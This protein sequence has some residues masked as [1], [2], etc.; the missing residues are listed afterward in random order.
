MKLIDN[1]FE[2]IK[3]DEITKKGKSIIVNKEYVIKKDGNNITNLYDYLESRGFINFPTILFNKNGYNVF[4]YLDDS[5]NPKEQKAYDIFTLISLLHEKTTYY[6]PIDIDEYKEIYENLLNEINYKLNYYNNLIS[7]IETHMFWSPSEYL[8]ARNISKILGALN[9]SKNNLDNWYDIVKTKSNKRIVTI[10]NNMD[11][12][13]L[14]RN[15]KLYL[16]SWDKSKKDIPIYD[17]YE[18]Y[19]KYYNLFDF[20]EL[21]K[22]YEDK[23]KLSKDEKELL[24]TLISIPPLLKKGKEE[25]NNCKNVKQI[26]DYLYKSEVVVS[27]INNN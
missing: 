21:L 18:F 14:I 7:T 25:I 8:I 9:Y 2:N 20:V 27:K 23:Y 1:L 22:H 13:H 16:L 24:C 10:Y 11:L 6:K 4:E 5:K 17:L 19:N 12:D 15:D 26:I 3:I